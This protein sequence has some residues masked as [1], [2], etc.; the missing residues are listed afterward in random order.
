MERDRKLE[1]C[2]A[3]MRLATAA[4][5]LVWAIDKVLNPKSAQAVF[6]NFY[7][8]KNASPDVLAIIGI[9]QAAIVVAFALGLLKLW[10]YGA[11]LAMH[12]VST[13]ASLGKM[14]PP[15]G[16]NASKV[17]WASVPVLAA[18]AALFV[19]RDRDR[20]LCLPPFGR[21]T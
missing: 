7:F 18:M 19:L 2:L 20:L 12:A 5:L 21:R 17:F 13:L 10:S 4:F 16:P 1:A 14:I 9:V 11:V 8:W 6:A 15:Y 3:A